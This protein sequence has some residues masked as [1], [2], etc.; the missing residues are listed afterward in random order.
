MRRDYSKEPG[1][2]RQTQ[3]GIGGFRVGFTLVELL[4]VIGIIAL[5]ISILLPSLNR[6]REAA[7]RVQCQ[8]NLR[9]LDQ[10][11]IMYANANRGGLPFASRN[12]KGSNTDEDFLYW[13][14]WR[15]KRFDESPIFKYMS[16]SKT[17]VGVLRCPSDQFD[18]RVKQNDVTQIGP[19]NFSY[20]M[21][22]WIAGSTL[23]GKKGSNAVTWCK[24]N[25][26]K[27]LIPLV[28]RKLTQVKHSSD[29]I[30]LYEED[31]ATIDDGNGYLWNAGLHVNLLA[32]RHDQKMLREKDVSVDNTK[33]VPNPGA[34]GNVAYCDGHVDFVARSV[35]HTREHALGGEATR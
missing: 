32:L 30:L 11:M 24:D 5:L 12:S 23:D 2:S 19:Y 15:V 6:A 1:C 25:G 21:N 27:E 17:S 22:F 18:V 31:V 28:C 13:Q 29:K 16:G 4:V 7:K 9:Q 3:A 35:A 10:A 8:S 20:A 33:P 26:H 34:K 14:K